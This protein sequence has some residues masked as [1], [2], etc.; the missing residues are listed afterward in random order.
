MKESVFIGMRKTT[1]L[2][3]V[4]FLLG[5][6]CSCRSYRYI[7]SAPPVNNPLFREKGESKL[8]VLYSGGDRDYNDNSSSNKATRNEGV[9]IQ[10]AYAITNHLAVTGS[11][12]SRGERDLYDNSTLHTDLYN[13]SDVDYKRQLT[14]F[15]IGYYGTSDKKKMNTW[16][17]YAG[18]GF[19]KF[20]IN[21]HGLDDT[22]GAYS[23]FYD[24]NITKW[25]LQP[26]LNFWIHDILSFGLS[27]RFSFIHYSG[28]T[29]SYTKEEQHYFFFDQI[30][31]KTLIN[32]EPS[33]NVEVPVH[34]APWLKFSGDIT[35]VSHWPDGY[36]SSR[37]INISGGLTFDL[38]QIG[39]KN[40]ST[41]RK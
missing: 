10:G 20:S 37:Q 33:L 22:S 35:V 24:A 32:V 38:S 5:F 26:S 14:D 23:R 11:Y 18:I 19:G 29:T 15:G 3:I 34:A 30:N 28:N 7:Y 2:I 36:P 13:Y 12:Y 21:D 9:D 31:D 6:L 16:N 17:L 39:R 40:K 4:I 27:A 1:N 41:T 8:S 25:Y